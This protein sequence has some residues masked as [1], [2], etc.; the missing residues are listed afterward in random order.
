M[1]NIY[2]PF[3]LFWFCI[4]LHFPRTYCLSINASPLARAS[5]RYKLIS[6]VPTTTA[7]KETPNLDRATDCCVCAEDSR[8]AHPEHT[9]GYS[10]ASQSVQEALGRDE[11]LLGTKT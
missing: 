6:F 8:S 1:R 11:F 5:L 9:E 3:T 4:E 10:L 7:Q 2:G